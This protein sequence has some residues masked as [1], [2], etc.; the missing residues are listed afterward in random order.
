MHT[1]TASSSMSSSLFHS[2]NCKHICLIGLSFNGTDAGIW[3][4]YDL[5]NPCHHYPASVKS[6]FIVLAS[7][8]S[9]A[10]LL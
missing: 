9:F 6:L 3:E 4:I 5:T 8:A 10:M 7:P 2:Q 1:K